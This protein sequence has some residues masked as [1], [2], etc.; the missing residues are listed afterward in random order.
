MATDGN[1]VVAWPIPC[2][3][4][5][6]GPATIELLL[7]HGADHRAKITVDHY[8]TPREDEETFGRLRV[9]EALH[10]VTAQ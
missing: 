1:V 5:M 6:R 7:K 8:I 10:K 9:V 3:R 2:A 4:A